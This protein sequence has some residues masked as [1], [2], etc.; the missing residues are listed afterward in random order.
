V[1]VQVF[2]VC[3][4]S[5]FVTRNSDQLRSRRLNPRHLLIWRF[6]YGSTR[7]KSTDFPWHKPCWTRINPC[8]CRFTPCP[9]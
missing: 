5:L 2:S 6:P 8:P 3:T 9:T 1:T 7:R 4:T